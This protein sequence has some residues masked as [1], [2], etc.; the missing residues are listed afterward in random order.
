MIWRVEQITKKPS[1]YN[2]TLEDMWF[3]ELPQPSEES[4][5]KR[6]KIKGK[7][8]VYCVLSVV[9]G[10]NDEGKKTLR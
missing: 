7:Q 9:G 10:E 8:H 6:Q 5:S 1:W 3:E 2:R 4:P